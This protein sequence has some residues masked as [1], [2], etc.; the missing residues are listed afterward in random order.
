M[1]DNQVGHPADGSSRL[2]QAYHVDIDK[3]SQ[4]Q[5]FQQLAANASCPH[6]QD[7][8]GLDLYWKQMEWVQVNFSAADQADKL[9]VLTLLLVSADLARAGHI[10]IADQPI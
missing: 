4:H 7:L 1:N 9:C 8:G 6:A 3:T 5:S 10:V 2:G